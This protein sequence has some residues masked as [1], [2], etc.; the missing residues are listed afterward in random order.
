KYKNIGWICQ[1]NIFP[2]Q[3]GNAVF[4]FSKHADSP[5]SRRVLAVCDFLIINNDELVKRRKI[6]NLQTTS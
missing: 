6:N 5:A 2:K 1:G 3:S 4:L